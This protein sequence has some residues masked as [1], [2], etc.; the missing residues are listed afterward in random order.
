MQE[1]MLIK[2]DCM[3]AGKDALNIL[4]QS[5]YYNHNLPTLVF[6]NY[7]HLSSV[8]IHNFVSE[9]STSN[10]HRIICFPW[11]TNFQFNTKPVHVAMNVHSPSF[12]L[13]MTGFWALHSSNCSLWGTQYLINLSKSCA[14]TMQ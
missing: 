3:D 11:C 12:S 1:V 10:K 14:V 8:V 6:L 13:L 5:S 4:F 7:N 2:L 9:M